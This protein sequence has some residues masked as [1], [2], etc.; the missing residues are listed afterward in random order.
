MESESPYVLC[1]RL[2]AQIINMLSFLDVQSL[3][4]DEQKIIRDLKRDV[5]DARLDIQDYELAETREQQLKDAKEAKKRLDQVRNGILAASEHN[6]FSAI[7]VA[8]LSA[9]IEQIK[10]RIR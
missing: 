3:S 9:N 4:Q 8:Q 5:I 7:D 1:K 2:E 6:V 10:G